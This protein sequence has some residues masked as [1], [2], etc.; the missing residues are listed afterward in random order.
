[1]NKQR[2]MPNVTVCYELL[3][4]I[5]RTT[6]ARGV[7]P[8]I[9][10]HDAIVGQFLFWTLHETG[11]AVFDIFQVPLF[12]REEDAVDPRPLRR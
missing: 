11:P 2:S 1:M 4:N 3:Q 7:R 10:Q 12:G 8:G 6:P 5:V 9:T